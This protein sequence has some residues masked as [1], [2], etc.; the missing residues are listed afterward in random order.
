MFKII[1]LKAVKVLPLMKTHYI[2]E[3]VVY[4]EVIYFV[5]MLVGRTFD[6]LVFVV[7]G[8]HD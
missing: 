6:V 7:R 3:D 5:E 8:L 2:I 1:K 4:S